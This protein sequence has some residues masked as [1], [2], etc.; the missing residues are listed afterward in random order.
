MYDQPFTNAVIEEAKQRRKSPLSSSE[1]IDENENNKD[2]E[3]ASGSVKKNIFTCFC[4]SFI[5]GD[6]ESSHDSVVLVR[7]F[8]CCSEIY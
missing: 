8:Y 2:S 1:E 5:P 3:K 6:V 7:S 4:V